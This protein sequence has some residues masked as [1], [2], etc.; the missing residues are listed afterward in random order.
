MEKFGRGVKKMLTKEE[1][2]RKIEENNEKIKKYGVKRIG[3]FGSFV[4]GEQKEGSDL[5]FVVEFE[6]GGKSYNNFINLVFFLEGLFDKK[7]D[8]LTREG[9]K[10]IRIKEVRERIERS[11]EYEANI[12]KNRRAGQNN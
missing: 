7:V 10:S 5:D 1:I 3:I 11:V 12:R 8:L 6:E 2:L 4:R 9:V